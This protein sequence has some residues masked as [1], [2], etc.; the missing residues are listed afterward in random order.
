MAVGV[1]VLDH[2]HVSNVTSYASAS[3]SPA[4]NALLLLWV[5]AADNDLVSPIPSVSGNGLSWVQVATSNVV[6]ADL[7]FAQRMTCYRAM[8]A[9][10]S[11]GT[12][13]MDWS[14][15]Q[16]QVAGHSLLQF[17]GIRTDG[18]SGAGAVGQFGAQSDGGDNSSNTISGF[19]LQDAASVLA[20]A[21][22]HNTNEATTAG[23]GYTSD[24][25]ESGAFWGSMLTQH[26]LN[27]T[28][29]DWTWAT[30]SKTAAIAVEVRAEI[31]MPY[32]R[33]IVP[34]GGV[35]QAVR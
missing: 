8:G 9:A 24:V 29:C 5:I 34:V 2:T 27:A 32:H 7:S 6:Y 20:G 26:K 33:S 31:R 15:D 23:S 22:F 14:G 11:T 1:S 4:A 30:A 28:V 17:T 18:V 10:P 13:T 12:V 3:V 35:R 25:T 16:Q 21:C 19:V